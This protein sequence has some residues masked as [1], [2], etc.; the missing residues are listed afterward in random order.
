MYAFLRSLAQFAD[1]SLPLRVIKAFASMRRFLLPQH[2]CHLEP[3]TGS[4]IKVE[5][6]VSGCAIAS[7]H[8]GRRTTQGST[9]GPPSGQTNRSNHLRHRRRA[10]HRD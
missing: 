2:D 3:T 6:V 10:L 1:N 7:H 5:D 4:V 9:P 8:M